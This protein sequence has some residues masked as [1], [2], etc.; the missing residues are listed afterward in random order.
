ML[1]RLLVFLTALLLSFT[2][3]SN[4]GM[5]LAEETTKKVNILH[6]NDIHARVF[7]ED[8]NGMGYAKI[9]SY[10]NQ[11]RSDNP[12]TLV[13]DAG[14]T[15]HGLSFAT[16][17]KG[18]SI[19][20]LLNLLKVDA[21][22]VGNHDFNYGSDRLLELTK[23]ANF[24][25]IAA[26]VEKK[27]GSDYLGDYIIKEIDGISIGIFGLA[28]PETTYKTNPNNVASLNFKNPVESAKEMVK[29]LQAEN[30]DYIIAL[31]HLGVDKGSLDTS[32]KVADEV[33]GI[34]LIV[35]GHSHTAFPKGELRNNTLIVST[36]EYSKNL[37]VVEIEFNAENKAV[38]TSAKLITKEEAK[39]IEADPAATKLIEEI[40]LSY[41]P[42]VDEVVGS[43]KVRLE[44]AREN[45]RTKETNL[46]NLLT[47]A[48][49]EAANADVAITNGGGIRASVEAG[50]VTRGELIEVAPFGNFVVTKYLTGAQIIASLEN[51]AS[52]YP[53]ANGAF[54]HVSGLNYSIDENAPAG[55]RVH[56][57]KVDGKPID[58][59][60]KYL[61]ATND[62]LAT[63]GDEYTEFGKEPTVNEFPALEEVMISYFQKHGEVNPAVEGRIVV[64]PKSVSGPTEPEKPEVPVVT[65]SLVYWD[66]LVLK[67]GQIGRITIQK[68]I[69]LW[70]KTE[71]GK[72]Q[73]VRILNPG[74][75]Y[76][77]YGY[78]PDHFGQYAVGAG[79]YVTKM[80]NYIKYE[81]PSKAKLNLLYGS[82]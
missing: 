46:G 75:I 14:D 70:K 9:A 11:Y 45:V 27:D 64:E 50:E 58:L 17:T 63:G 21:M 61:V 34:D 5:V 82:K 13:L 69:N 15:L 23:M 1:K 19:M 51:G 40:K 71:N 3:F 60:K 42:I 66:G 2:F 25:V 35:D 32:Y 41:K 77:V 16:L 22:T 38:S 68:P 6:M 73:F 44:G 10:V 29:T 20:Q 47:D 4:T 30:V 80:D 12:N 57:V 74:E 56:N 55:E 37:G 7:E 72:L 49:R 36:G 81:T 62:F 48:M 65:P 53:A 31:A 67:Q 24:P 59:D 43:T 79:Y 18:E 78:S 52:D 28:T 26:N 8:S 39:S 33:E 54:S 76:R